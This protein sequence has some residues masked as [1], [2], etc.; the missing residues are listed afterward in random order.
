MSYHNHSHN[1][2]IFLI[3]FRGLLAIIHNFIYL[4]QDSKYFPHLDISHYP[5]KIIH[6]SHISF[7]IE[8]LML[9][10]HLIKESYDV[11]YSNGSMLKVFVFKVIKDCKEGLGRHYCTI[12]KISKHDVHVHLACTSIQASGLLTSSLMQTSKRK[13]I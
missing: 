7:F 3:H 2:I 13:I 12:R 5:A 10:M 11:M 4:G 9:P 6:N 1:H 8:F